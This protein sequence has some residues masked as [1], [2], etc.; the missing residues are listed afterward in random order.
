LPTCSRDYN[1]EGTAELTL[2][3]HTAGRPETTGRVTVGGSKYS[4][5]AL[6]APV[7]ADAMRSHAGLDEAIS[8]GSNLSDE[9]PLVED[10]LA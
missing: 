2:E 6:E 9:G 5:R 8:T 7:R 1:I 3:A 10:R 4:R